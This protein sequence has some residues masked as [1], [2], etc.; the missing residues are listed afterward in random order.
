MPRSSREA[1][2]PP[3]TPRG[4]DVPRRKEKASVE[5]PK[6]AATFKDEGDSAYLVTDKST[7]LKWLKRHTPGNNPK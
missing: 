4:H 1:G 6:A 2:T 3:R 7:G 5:R